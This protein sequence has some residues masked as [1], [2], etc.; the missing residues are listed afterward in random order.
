MT[1]RHLMTPDQLE[2]ERQQLADY[3]LSTTLT[4]GEL[5]QRARDLAAC[6]QGKG[7]SSVWGIPQG[8]AVPA[9]LVARHLGVPVA[10]QP[11]E[12]TLIVDDLIATGHTARKVLEATPH[13]GFDALYRK[14]FSP[15]DL[16]RHAGP[17]VGWLRFPWERDGGDPTDAVVRLIEHVGED[18]RREGLVDTPRRVVKAL[19]EMTAGYGEDPV[20][21]LRSAVFHEPGADEL[22]VAGPFPIMSLCE[23]HV[24][25]FTGHCVIG[26]IPGGGRITGLSKLPRAA[27]AVFRRLQ[28][29]ERATAE[30]ADA[31][32]EALNPDGVAV[33]VRA[34]HACAE[35][36]GVRT[37]TPMVTSVQRGFLR[38]RP[39]AR[40]ELLD[41]IG[42][43]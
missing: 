28:V 16:A 14:P 9:V 43:M 13:L 5:D 34:V 6:W 8:G 11:D 23:H 21:I 35:L 18:P 19:R 2:R 4:W 1:S 29:Q 42:G 32:V 33:V 37:R 41:L 3:R 20:A 27:H 22:I 7:V 25:P 30:I 10:D 36:R 26:Y 17:V 40:A 12:H 38:D 15:A 39:A 31:M 24:L